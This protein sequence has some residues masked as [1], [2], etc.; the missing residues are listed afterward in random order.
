MR[1]DTPSD[2]FT[3]LPIMIKKKKKKK[4]IDRNKRIHM[5]YNSKNYEKRSLST[6]M[7]R[8]PS[9]RSVQPQSLT[10]SVILDSLGSPW[11]SSNAV[12]TSWATVVR[13]LRSSSDERALLVPPLLVFG[14]VVGSMHKSAMVCSSSAKNRGT[15]AARLARCLAAKSSTGV[16][17]SL[18]S[19]APP[20]AETAGIARISSTSCSR[21]RSKCNCSWVSSSSGF[22]SLISSMAAWIW[23][24]RM[25]DLIAIRL[26]CS[27][28]WPGPLSCPSSAFCARLVRLVLLVSSMLLLLLLVPVLLPL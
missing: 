23:P 9:S 14:A 16:I 13:R 26:G 3:N 6:V 15:A 27:R 12:F 7:R 25:S 1:I 20:P 22:T 4:K 11:A 18:V 5:Q 2:L 28:S 8:L 10:R 21:S 24:E 17:I 19:S